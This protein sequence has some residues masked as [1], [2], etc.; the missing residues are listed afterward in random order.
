MAR[1]VGGGGWGGGG[2]Q[3]L[4]KSRESQTN[5][6]ARA[7]TIDAHRFISQVPQFWELKTRLD[8]QT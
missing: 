4:L 8:P 2:V 6:L 3:K 5:K 1:G 7:T